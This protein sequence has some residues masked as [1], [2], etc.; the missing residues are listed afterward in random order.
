MQE[1]AQMSNKVPN[2]KK[3]KYLRTEFLESLKTQSDSSQEDLKKKKLNYLLFTV[4][5]SISVQK[6]ILY[7]SDIQMKII[8][9]QKNVALRST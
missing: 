5:F 3:Y 1:Q 8:D 2:F 9:N 7:S 4:P 6:V